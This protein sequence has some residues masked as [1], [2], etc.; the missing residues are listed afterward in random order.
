MILIG[1]QRNFIISAILLA[2][3][4][5][6]MSSFATMCNTSVQIQSSS[7]MRGR[8][9]AAYNLVFVGSTPLGSLY[10]GQISDMLGSDAGFLVSGIIGLLFLLSMRLFVTPKAFMDIKSFAQLKDS[11]G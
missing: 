10:T 5:F 4:G 1:L 11:E 8:V 2:A 9:M 3:C 7:A 6:G